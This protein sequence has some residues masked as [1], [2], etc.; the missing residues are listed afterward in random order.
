M[1]N[2]HYGMK[3]PEAIGRKIVMALTL[4]VTLA[5]AAQGWVYLDWWRPASA[6]KVESLRTEFQISARDQRQN[7]RNIMRIILQEKVT[8]LQDRVIETDR[9]IEKLKRSGE[10]VPDIY[11]N[12]KRLFQ[13]QIQTVMNQLNSLEKRERADQ[14]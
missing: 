11:Y 9:V 1:S 2:D 12:Q 4:I 3:L 10:V 5:A 6:Q 7:T 14:P 13:K 8:V